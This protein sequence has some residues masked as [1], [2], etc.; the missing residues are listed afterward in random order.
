MALLAI[1]TSFLTVD[2]MSLLLQRLKKGSELWDRVVNMARR[3][4]IK[5]IESIAAFGLGNI[6]SA[7]RTIQTGRH[8]GKI[9]LKPRKGESGKVM[10]QGAP[11]L[12]S[13]NDLGSRNG[14][15]GRLCC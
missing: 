2:F 10:P 5:P 1:S 6:E 9:V 3:Q 4:E 14:R 7:M 15:W 13:D 12:G 11:C 8:I